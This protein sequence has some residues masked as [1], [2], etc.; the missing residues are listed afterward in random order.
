MIAGVDQPL[1]QANCR[2][3]QGPIKK[4]MKRR[5]LV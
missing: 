3:F 5:M 1:Q 2:R 4:Q